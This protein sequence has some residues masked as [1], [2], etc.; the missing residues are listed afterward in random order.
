MTIRP[1][2]MGIEVVP[3]DALWMALPICGQTYPAA[4]PIP[5]ARKIHRVKKRSRK[6]RRFT[7]DTSAHRQCDSHAA[8]FDLALLIRPRLQHGAHSVARNLHQMLSLLSSAGSKQGI[9]NLERRQTLVDDPG[10]RFDVGAGEITLQLHRLVDRCGLRE[11]D[12]QDVSERRI[13]QPGQEGAAPPGSCRWAC[14]V[15]RGGRL[16]RRRAR[17][18]CGRSAPCR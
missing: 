11:R 17:A 2:A 18:A 1:M 10:E 3:M 9:R 6:E 16:R 4:T 13:P 5:M 14:E 8:R 15:P 7:P 12:E